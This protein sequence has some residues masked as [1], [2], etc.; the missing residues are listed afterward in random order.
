MRRDRLTEQVRRSARR[1]EE[2]HHR[3]AAELDAMKTVR[4]ELVAAF[5]TRIS[6]IELNTG[7]ITDLERELVA[8]REALAAHAADTKRHTGK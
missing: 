3:I 2:R 4:A 1:G 5:E 6:Q 7:R 8:V